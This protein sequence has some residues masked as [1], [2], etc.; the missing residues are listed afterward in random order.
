[1]ECEK[2]FFLHKIAKSFLNFKIEHFADLRKNKKDTH[3][4]G[5]RVSRRVCGKLLRV[6]NNFWFYSY[7]RNKKSDNILCKF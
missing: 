6:R 7:N 4:G 5:N 1:M 3:T 2:L